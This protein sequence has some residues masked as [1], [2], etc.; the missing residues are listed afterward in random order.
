MRSEQ[1]AEGQRRKSPMC[2]IGKGGDLERIRSRVRGAK[3]FCAKC[4][5]AAHDRIYLC[6]PTGI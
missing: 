4:G 3:F 1:N 5:R 2:K 6:K